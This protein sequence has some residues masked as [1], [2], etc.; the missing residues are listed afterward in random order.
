MK[1]FRRYIAITLSAFIA[2][3]AIWQGYKFY[4]SQAILKDIKKELLSDIVLGNP[5]AK[6]N[7][8]VFFDYNCTYCQQFIKEVYPELQRGVF[9]KY[10]LKITLRLVCRSTDVKAT[11]AYQTAI[12]LYQAGGD[13]MKL[14]QLLMHEPAIIYSDYFTQIRED[15]IHSNELLAECI[16]NKENEDVKRN[17][18]QFQHLETRGTPTFIVGNNVIKGF[19]NK[20]VFESIVASEFN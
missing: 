8:I 13:Y 12:C 2:L 1:Y 17:I 14:H 4:Q 20:Q 5:T 18:F 16:L 11:A 6:N 9:E 3:L 10:D 19:K 7:V 15:Y